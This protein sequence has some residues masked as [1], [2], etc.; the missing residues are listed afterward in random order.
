MEMS[1]NPA[2][3]SSASTER[4]L[5]SSLTS[6]TS[7]SGMSDQPGADTKARERGCRVRML[8]EARAALPSSTTDL[9][10]AMLSSSVWSMRESSTVGQA[11]KCTDTGACSSVERNKSCQ[12]RSLMKGV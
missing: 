9:T 2:S 3:E 7:S 10:L 5:S 12:T 1:T 6:A 11:A 8:L 4:T